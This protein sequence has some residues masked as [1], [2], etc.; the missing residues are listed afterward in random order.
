MPFHW[1]QAHD[2]DGC[3][4]AVTNEARDPLS[5]EPEFKFSAVRLEKAA[6]SA[7]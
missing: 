3:V 1:G 4:N 7:A 2:P 5:L 6:P